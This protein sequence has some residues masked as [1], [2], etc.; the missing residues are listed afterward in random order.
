MLQPGCAT[1]QFVRLREKPRNPLAER[2]KTT[3][4]GHLR[5]SVR[6]EQFLRTTGY[7]GPDQLEDLLRHTSAETARRP[8]HDSL[9]A[10]A[11]LNYLGAEAMSGK[12]AQLASELYLDAAH[13][14]WYY[15]ATA[16]SS[17]Q[18][19]SPNSASHRDAAEIYNAGSEAVLR[20]AKKHG[21]YMLGRSVEMPLTGRRLLFEIP[22]ETRHLSP[23]QLSEFEFVTDYKLQNLRHHHATD[24]LGVPIIAVRNTA[25]K[26]QPIEEYYTKGMSI[27]ATAVLRFPEGMPPSTG[28]RE[29]PIRLQ[30]LDPRESD[31]IVIGETLMPLDVYCRF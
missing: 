11:E 5:P 8:T 28:S 12:D 30:I 15:F 21:S 6:T 31:G 13:A 3:N 4:L 25:P 1:T 20:I 22:F 16:D 10:Q 9:H 7:R 19:P 18:L 17:G 29:L 24:G 23:G 2:L 27:A 14:G 26:P